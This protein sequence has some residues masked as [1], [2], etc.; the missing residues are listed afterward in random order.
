MA[1]AFPGKRDHEAPAEDGMS[2]GIWVAVEQERGRAAMVS[3]ELLGVAAGLAEQLE[4]ETA[5]VIFGHEESTG[6]L[7][8]EAFAFGASRVLTVTDPALE[9]FAAAPHCRALTNLARAWQP[10]IILLGA[11]VRGRDLAAAAATDLQTGLTADCTGLE[12]EAGSG[13]L[14]QTRPAY[15]GNVMA[16]IVTPA[17]KPQMAT[18]R[19]GVF[20]LPDAVPGRAGTASSH[21]FD[22]AADAGAVRQLEFIAEA[23]QGAGLAEAQVIVAGGRGLRRAEGFAMLEELAAELGGVVAASRGAVDAGWREPRYQVGQTGQTVRPRLY[24]AVGISGAVQHLA[25]MQ[26]AGVI[27][28]INSDPR[29]PIFGVADYGIAGDLFEVVPA[30]TAALGRRRKSSAPRTALGE[31]LSQGPEP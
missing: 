10:D 14:Y 23:R 5:A 26:E 1:E 19:P 29:A 22:F 7:A 11:T 2:G 24:L 30:L 12:I 18:V 27:A 16:T 6:Q 8:G 4:C 13:L 15:G 17:H 9:P 21:S 31:A 20:P 28:A 25:G 3:W